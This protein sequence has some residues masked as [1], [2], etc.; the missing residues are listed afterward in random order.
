M[1]VIVI[2][3][4]ALGLSVAAC[5]TKDPSMG[6]G[7]KGGVLGASAGERTGSGGVPGAA[8][9]PGSAGGG[10]T[11]GRGGSNVTVGAGGTS[12]GEG[13][14]HA[15]DAGVPPVDAG[16]ADASSVPCPCGERCNSCPATAPQCPGA[17]AYC[18]PSGACVI[19]GPPVCP[20]GSGGMGAGGRSCVT[21]ADCGPNPGAACAQSCSDGSNPCS[22]ACRNGFCAQRG[23]VS[24]GGGAGGQG[25]GGG[26]G[27][28]GDTSFV[29]TGSAGASGTCTTGSTFC[30]VRNMRSGGSTAA[31]ESFTDASR[32]ADCSSNP[33]CACLCSNAWFFCNTECRCSESAGEVIVTC[34]PV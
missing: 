13:G 30:H 10:G 11:A 23:C 27:A 33:S 31:C 6:S 7:A 29:C 9:N 24:G 21:V 34:D 18:D 26:G 20:S 2:L 25:M 19:G 22:Y 14:G 4:I 15:D 5:N 3:A 8:G 17:I 12:T 16:G 28:A 1:N 32:N